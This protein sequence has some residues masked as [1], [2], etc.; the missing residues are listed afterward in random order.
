MYNNGIGSMLLAGVL[1][2]GASVSQAQSVP[3]QVSSSAQQV[4]HYID[5]WVEFYPSAAFGQGLKPAALLFEDFSEP[6]V[7]DWIAFNRVTEDIMSSLP[8]SAPLQE[9]IDARVLLRQVKFE[10]GLWDDD[11]VLSHQPQWYVEQI[12]DALALVLVSEK[13]SPTEKYTAVV[14]RMAGIG[15]LVEVGIRNLRDGNPAR[16][17]VALKTLEQTIAYFENDLPTLPDTWIAE[18]DRDV[19]KDQSVD[20]AQ[21]LRELEQ[22][23]RDEVLPVA[24]VPNNFGPEVYTRKLAVYSDNSLTPDSL[25]EQ[26]LEEINHVRGLMRN[27]AL[28][29]WNAANEGLIVPEDQVLLDAALA[30]ME[31]DRSDN[32]KDFLKVFSD[33]TNRAIDFVGEH[34]LATLPKNHKIIVDMYPTHHSHATIGGVY[35]PGPFDPGAETLLYLPSIADDAPEE[36]KDGFYRSFNDHFNNMIDPHELF[37]GH[38]MQFKVGLEYAPKIRTLFHNQYYSEGWASL[39]EIIMLNAGWADG[40]KLTYLAHLR[41]RLENAT[42]A[43]ISVMVHTRGWNKE[44]VM[45]FAS[46]RGQLP[47]QFAENLW[48]RASGLYNAL[49]LTSYFV[50][51]H[52]IKEIWQQE[53]QRLGANFVQKDFIDTVLR[54]GS[55]SIGSLGEIIKHQQPTGKAPCLNHR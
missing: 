10:L 40:N 25:T 14:N 5:R 35:P 54:A 45:E 26:A 17:E 22:H 32:R 7:T 24:S 36:A 28:E 51:S 33:A 34:D 31:E 47:P 12:S 44:Q 13:L 9:R 52:G 23:I 50:G 18:S 4:D 20:T 29:W 43:Y 30:A 6:R 16:I 11:K 8:Q 46:T 42:R 3:D 37:P 2:L 41:K 48:Y 19:F 39:S 1:F 55:V 21:K 49:Q 38:D 27:T 15:A 53:K